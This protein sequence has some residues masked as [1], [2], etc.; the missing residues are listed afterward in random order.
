MKRAAAHEG[1][2][3]LGPPLAEHEPSIPVDILARATQ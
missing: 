1:Q 2:Q 3:I